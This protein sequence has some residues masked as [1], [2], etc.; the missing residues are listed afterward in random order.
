[1]GGESVFFNCILPAASNGNRFPNGLIGLKARGS[2]WPGRVIYLCWKI[3]KRFGLNGK[4]T[5]TPWITAPCIINIHFGAHNFHM[6]VHQG[7]G[8]NKRKQ[9][10]W[11]G[12]SYRLAGPCRLHILATGC[13]RPRHA[14]T[15]APS[16][17]PFITFFQQTG[18]K[19]SAKN[20]NNKQSW[21][22]GGHWGGTQ[23]FKRNRT[24]G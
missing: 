1:M 12:K 4:V 7:Y 21:N 6:L 19:D 13:I 16:S 9:L 8:R 17:F 15:T 24:K 22:G 2:F 14:L 20:I 11:F 5:H 18:Q 10:P 3:D 23:G